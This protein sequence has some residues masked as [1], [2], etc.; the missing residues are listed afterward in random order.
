MWLPR[1]FCSSANPKRADLADDLRKWQNP[2]RHSASGVISIQLQTLAPNE[3]LF[4]NVPR[5]LV[6]T[7]MVKTLNRDLAAAGIPKTDDR[8]RTVDVHALRH[9]F[10]TLLSTSGV[11]PRTAQQAMRHSK[12]ELTPN[13]YTDSR[14]QDVAGAIESLPSLPIP[15]LDSMPEPNRNVVTGSDDGA[16]F[17][18]PMVAPKADFQVQRMS[19]QDKKKQI[20]TTY[21][22]SAQ[23][24]K[25]AHIN[26]CF[27]GLC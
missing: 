15:D 25:T 27:C 20:A 3:P 24:T 4:E 5:Q 21:C 17:V 6:K 8:G 14:L 26:R 7:L 11:T 1:R 13:T 16:S 23:N 19:K 22:K 2:K 10:G 9:S 12:I 18:A